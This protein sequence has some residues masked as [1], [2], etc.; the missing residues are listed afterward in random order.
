MTRENVVP[1][2]DPITNN[3]S[4]PIRILLALVP[5]TFIS[6][7]LSL[8]VHEVIGHAWVSRWF[9]SVEN[10]FYVAPG[11]V[12]YASWN[13]PDGVTLVQRNIISAGGAVS[14]MVFGLGL[15]LLAVLLARKSQHWIHGMLAIGGALSFGSDA[16]YLAISPLI[17]WGDG[18]SL[19]RNGVPPYVFVIFGVVSTSFLLGIFI[20]RAVK[21]LSSYY[22]ATSFLRAWAVFAAVM[23]V[24]YFYNLA[25]AYL[26]F[27]EHFPRKVIYLCLTLVLS[28]LIGF[29]VY[30]SP[31]LSKNHQSPATRKMPATGV[32]VLWVIAVIM[33]I[34]FTLYFGLNMEM[35]P[36]F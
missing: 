15:F 1:S 25:K 24:P 31:L 22:D 21:M 34:G 11:I 30:K 29:V 36:L 16:A 7:T 14:G 9:G 18:Y 17:E 5:F 28:P 12:G 10:S 4:T 35:K 26:F 20:P 6:G 27:Q 3:N 32:V 8:V 2:M 19:L 33:E 23:I 13:N